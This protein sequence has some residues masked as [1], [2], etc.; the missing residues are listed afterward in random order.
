[1]RSNVNVSSDS[2]LRAAY[3][4]F[5]KDRIGEANILASHSAGHLGAG[6]PQ[7]ANSRFSYITRQLNSPS[8]VKTLCR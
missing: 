6:L 7:R 2:P 5:E 4:F 8:H 3:R 1:M